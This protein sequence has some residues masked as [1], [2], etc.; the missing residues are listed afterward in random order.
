[1]RDEAMH[2][3]LGHAQVDPG[4]DAAFEMLDRYSEAVVGGTDAARRYPE[5]QRHI[6]NCSAC[7][8]DT[9]GLVALLIVGIL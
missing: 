9:D 6:D 8:E 1:M 7:R 2:R 5:F 4:C 3:L